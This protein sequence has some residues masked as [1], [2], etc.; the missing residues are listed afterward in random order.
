MTS[1]SCLW[2]KAR[3]N[4]PADVKEWLASLEYGI[5]PS[6]TATEQI[7]ALIEQTTTKQKDLE[8]SNHR[9]RKYF[10]KII[11][12]LDKVKGIGDVISSF[13]PVHAALP[14]AAFR[15]ALQVI[16]AEREQTD[17]VLQLLASTPH[18]VFSGRVLERVYT[19]ESINS[20]GPQEEVEIGQQ[21]I[22][23]LHDELIK[24][25]CALLGALKYC[26][27][28]VSQH[29]VKRKAT[30]IFNSSEV[31][32]IH[33]DLA[34]QHTKVLSCGETCHKF[35]SH[36]LS[37]KSLDL[38]AQVQP[39]LAELG[40]RVREL[41]VQID[42]SE[43]RKT[44]GAISSVMFRSHHEEVSRKRT[45]GT[46]EWILRK[47]KFIQWEESDS[48]IAILYGNPG[49]GKTF[50]ISRVIDYALEKAE[51][52]EGLAFFYCKRD[53]ENRRNPQ[54]ILRSILRQLSTPV[55]DIESGT[56]HAA[57]K[58]LPNKLALKGTTINVST[59]ENLLG[60]LVE[61]YPRTTIILDA[62]DECD[63]NTREELMRVFSNLASRSS[64]VRVFISSRHDEDIQRHFKNTPIIEMLATDNEE[65]IASFVEE[66]LLRDSRWVEISPELQKEI[67]AR[68]HEKSLGMFQWAALQVDQ[69]RRLKLWS[70]ANIRQ[71]LSISPTGLDAAYEVV[72]NQ[73]HEMSSYEQQLARRAFQWTLCAFRPL[74]T[75]ELSLMMHIDPDSGKKESDTVLEAETIQ[76]ICG[77]LLVY[78]L[79]SEVWRF[80]HLS[81]REYFENYHFNI[82]QCHYQVT[83][84]SIKFLERDLVWL[85]PDEKTQIVSPFR[86]V[87][88]IR[89]DPNSRCVEYTATCDYIVTN[90]FRHAHELDTPEFRH[91]ELSNLLQNFFEPI[92]KGSSSFQAWRR[93]SIE[94]ESSRSFL[95][96]TSRGSPIWEGLLATPLQ[97]MSTYGLFYILRGLWEKSEGEWDSFPKWLP[98]PLTLAIDH[99]HEYIWNFML[100]AKANVNSGIPR[101]LTA[102]IRHE[103]MEA[104]EAL[105]EAGADVNN[106]F[107]QPSS[108]EALSDLRNSCH[109]EPDEPLKTAL[110]V[111]NNESRRY[112]IERL[113]DQGAD[114]KLRTQF[115]SVLEIAVEYAD[116][117]TVGILLNANTEEY[118]PDHLL[119]LAAQNKI[120]NLVPLFVKLGANIEKPWE[121]VL[122]SVW[123]L[124]QGNLPNVRSLLEMSDTQMDLSCHKTREAFLSAL[125]TNCGTEIFPVL[126][127][128]GVSIDGRKVEA[129]VFDRALT[130]YSRY[131]R[132]LRLYPAHGPLPSPYLK[133]KSHHELS[134]FG[135]LLEALANFSDRTDVGFGSVLAGAAFHGRIYHCRAVLDHGEFHTEQERQDQFRNALF[136]VIRGHL[137]FRSRQSADDWWRPLGYEI[138]DPRHRRVLRL[139]FKRGL[140][141]YMPIYDS[142]APSLPVVQINLAGYEVSEP[143]LMYGRDHYAYFSRFWLFIMWHLQ[144]STSPQLPIRSQLRRWQFPGMLSPTF[145][146]VANLT[147]A[148][149]A[150]SNYFI[151]L[152]IRGNHSQFIIS[153]ASTEAR[154][155]LSHISDDKR[156]KRYKP[157]SFGVIRYSYHDLGVETSNTEDAIASR[158]FEA[159]QDSLRGNNMVW[160][161]LALIVGL[162]SCFFCSTSVDQGILVSISNVF[163]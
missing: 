113:V 39:S 98:S 24:L 94:K 33:K 82:L 136:A 64:K 6:A 12:W 157:E 143:C 102:A 26:H 90:V 109:M 84:S 38:L 73:I 92:S 158:K 23:S 46:C 79:Q 103:D 58:N 14:W 3:E 48:C 149:G 134:F 2:T 150:Q 13:D 95:N 123:A 59:C 160:I 162:F 71:Q 17:S 124:R 122:P 19:N 141:V 22:D 31:A 104:F 7:D 93:L 91:I 106:V 63:R 107:L 30:A 96:T 80:S 140:E 89:P 67:K 156:W 68:F 137:S 74:E 65:D 75:P 41:L 76:C 4:L 86:I 36:V 147:A 34:A 10:D 20:Q 45:K 50:I 32:S 121:G 129:D 60:E 161:F 77:N 62:L 18:L 131:E 116:E 11:Y 40:D 151:K 88:P 53:E 25:Y 144:N 111:F 114:V 51:T 44:L 117:E 66:K 125:K 35:L 105:L 153:P 108:L 97:V 49:A 99:G 101:P 112:F 130:L 119:R 29:K 5:Q 69:I 132:K 128:A 135:T 28:I 155:S 27:S 15:F 61:D 21:C 54:D 37:R 126:S 152:F 110:W 118:S 159:Y 146:I 138:L 139:L 52:S 81:A 127:N 1:S 70:E 8:K 100:L 87:A 163:E 142:L 56:I 85:P 42:V 9:F 133:A 148:S 72:W 55:R 57:L 16:L 78:D 83:I 145:T 154:R 115:E 47:N 43:R 120:F